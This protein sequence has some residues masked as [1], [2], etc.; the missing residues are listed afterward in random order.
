M[1]DCQ[2][3]DRHHEHDLVDEDEDLVDLDALKVLSSVKTLKV[4]FGDS[5]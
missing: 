5:Y 4:G 1:A 3:D 2:A